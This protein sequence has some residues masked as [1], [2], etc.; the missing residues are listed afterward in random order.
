MNSLLFHSFNVAVSDDDLAVF[1]SIFCR[2]DIDGS[3]F[4]TKQIYFE[5]IIKHKRNLV[6]EQIFDLIGTKAKEHISFGEFVDVC[7]SSLFVLVASMSL[8]DA[9]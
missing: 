8:V 5:N 2:N 7:H 4:V 3:G 6:A 1:W 9:L